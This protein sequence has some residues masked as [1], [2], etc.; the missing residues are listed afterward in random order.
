MYL[1]VATS[2]GIGVAGINYLSGVDRVPKELQRTV[3]KVSLMK[4]ALLGLTWP[5]LPYHLICGDPLNCIYGKMIEY[6]LYGVKYRVK[7]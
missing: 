1:R 5:I 7:W 3:L 2:I 4:G 6:D